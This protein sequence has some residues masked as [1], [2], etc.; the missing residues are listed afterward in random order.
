MSGSR[1]RRADIFRAAIIKCR[2]FG[3]PLVLLFIVTAGRVW[4]FNNEPSAL[5]S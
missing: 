1:A 4:Q 3:A 2:T 5:T